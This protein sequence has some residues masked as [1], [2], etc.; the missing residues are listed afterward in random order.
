MPLVS[1][2]RLRLRAW[3][4]A[5]GFL[6]DAVRSQNQARRAPGVLDVAV[7]NDA[8]RTFWTRTVWTDEAAMRDYVLSGPHRRVMPRLMDW[9][10]EASV[11]HWTQD[12]V[13]PPS[14]DEAWR[15]MQEDG[16]ASRVRHPSPDHVNFKITPMRAGAPGRNLG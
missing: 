8:R 3:R 12:S 9:C 14:W 16:R 4:F 2:T 5:P 7:Q 1:I 6:L 10:D 15:R 13:A 11:V